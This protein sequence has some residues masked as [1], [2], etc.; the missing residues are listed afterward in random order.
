VCCRRSKGEARQR[1]GGVKGG[2]KKKPKPCSPFELPVHIKPRKESFYR[3]FRV[4]SIMNA[5]RR[6]RRHV[7]LDSTLHLDHVGSLV[8]ATYSTLLTFWLFVCAQFGSWVYTDSAFSNLLASAS[9][10][11]QN[12]Y[13]SDPTTCDW[14]TPNVWKCPGGYVPPMC[15][16]WSATG[17]GAPYEIS[18]QIFVACGLGSAAITAIASFMVL[19]SSQ[20]TQWN[21]RSLAFGAF[22]TLVFACICLSV[23][24]TW[25]YMQS[26][27]SNTGSMPFYSTKNDKNTPV[28]YYNSSTFDMSVQYGVAYYC[29]ATAIASSILSGAL[30]VRAMWPVEHVCYFLSF[31]F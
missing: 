26:L 13:F 11:C 5:S 17:L 31:L 19:N 6:R 3:G 29:V 8:I 9:T 23:F 15:L 25:P 16:P 22:S 27:L 2:R 1:D 24:L 21:L 10:M 4:A 14:L 30:F 7:P 12:F 18:M 28:I 20:I